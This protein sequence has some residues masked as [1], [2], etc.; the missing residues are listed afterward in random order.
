MGRT[1]STSPNSDIG[2]LLPAKRRRQ[3]S[4]NWAK[5][6]QAIPEELEKGCRVERDWGEQEVCW[7]D[8]VGVRAYAR[9][10]RARSTKHAAN[11]SGLIELRELS[12]RARARA[13]ARIALLV[14]YPQL[15]Q[16]H[17]RPRPELVAS[18]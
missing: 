15:S 1:S 5:A 10:S 14:S 6:S 16:L 3:S 11:Q 18:G 7:A 12:E 17:P 13:T 2:P 9:V 8:F 4:S